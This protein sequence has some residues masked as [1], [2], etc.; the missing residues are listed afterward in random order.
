MPDGQA[1]VLSPGSDAR[2]GPHPVGRPGE[3]VRGNG[4]C[5]TEPPDAGVTGASAG[6]VG[7]AGFAC[8]VPDAG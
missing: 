1:R 5:E 7:V 3:G 2:S 8:E 4:Y 6:V